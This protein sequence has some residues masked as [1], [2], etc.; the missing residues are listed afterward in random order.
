MMGLARLLASPLA[1]DGAHLGQPLGGVGAD[2]LKARQGGTTLASCGDEL[3]TLQVCGET[4]TK[5]C[6]TPH[7]IPRSLS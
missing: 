1:H 4:M 6:S 2:R 5:A 7:S 3:V